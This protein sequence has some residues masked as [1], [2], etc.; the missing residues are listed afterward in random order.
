MKIGIDIRV[1][2]KKR[3]GEETYV[4]N[5]IKNLLKIDQKNQYFFY[6]DTNDKKIISEIKNKID[7]NN[8]FGNYNIIPVLPA[9]K[10]FWTFL[11]LPKFL[12]KNPVDILHVQHITPQFLPFETKLITTIHDVS[13]NVFPQHIKK[14]DLFFLKTLIPSSLKKADKII[15]VSEFTKKEVVSFYKVNKDKVEAIYNGGVGDKFKN[16][17]FNEEKR[18]E[19]KRRY[20]LPKY[21]ILYVGTLQPRK[22]I[23]FL[24]DGFENLRKEHKD[25]QK[26]KEIKLVIVGSQEGHN[27]DQ[28]IDKKLEELKNNKRNVYNDIIFTGYVKDL[29]LPWFYKMADVFCF[30]SLYEGFGLPL[31]EA[32]TMGKPVLCSDSSC[33]KEIAA[34]G[35]LYFQESDLENFTKSLFEIIMNED[36]KTLLRE[37]GRERSRFF[38][39]EKCARQT[40]EAY[41]NLNKK[42]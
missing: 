27:Y 21:F 1:V 7:S 23:P 41:R 20:N 14:S 35:A 29:E 12:R 8:Q 17:N 34:E 28:E 31:I 38:S 18:R 39:W 25:N 32:M 4:K 22:N 24:I 11:T 9:S 10:M 16:I 36:K 30:P 2:G 42:R 13:F 3:T 15:T 5:L 26:I 37:K 19:I 6:T 33:H 40:L